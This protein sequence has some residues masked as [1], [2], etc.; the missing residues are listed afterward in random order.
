[1]SMTIRD[2]F[3]KPSAWRPV[4]LLQQTALMQKAAIGIFNV[5]FPQQ[6]V[7]AVCF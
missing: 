7:V 5:S 6:L 1:M 4:L 2:I 3:I